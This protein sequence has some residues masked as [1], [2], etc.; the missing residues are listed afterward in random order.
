MRMKS[1]QKKFIIILF[2]ILICFIGVFSYVYRQIDQ[3]LSTIYK[4]RESE[5]EEKKNNQERK[6]LMKK[7]QPMNLLLLG[8]DE[9]PGDK[10]RTDTIILLSLNPN[11]KH[12]IMLS[13]PRDTYAE[14]PD[15]GKDKINHAYA[16]GN[17]DLTIQT[18]EKLLEL[19][20]HFYIKINME[21]F[22]NGIDTIGGVTVDNPLDFS[23]GKHHFP[24][25]KIHLNGDQ[26]LDYIRMRKDDPEGDLGR[27]KRQQIVL[28][29]AM[30]ESL[31]FFNLPKINSIL[32][33]LGENITTDI[34]KD[35]FQTLFLDYRSSL[36]TLHS[37]QINGKGQFI[38]PSWFYVISDDEINRIKKEVQIH[39]EKEAKDNILNTTNKQIK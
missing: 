35:H 2:L 34:E 15:F 31:K 25:G 21:G 33:I 39:M 1:S 18:V 32:K 29:A 10:G 17:V 19:P 24:S 9:R 14:I 26:A 22:K 13:I 5:I 16:Y 37:L 20:I 23:Q 12:T 6:K 36:Q 27:N 8:V 4:P 7:N 28:E 30:K 3:T 38:G 11:I